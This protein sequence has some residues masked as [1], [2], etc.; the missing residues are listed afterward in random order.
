MIETARTRVCARVRVEAA[1][2]AGRDACASSEGSA[3]SESGAAA[4]SSAPGEGSAPRLA[5]AEYE[6]GITINWQ[7]NKQ[8]TKSPNRKKVNSQVRK[9]PPN[10]LM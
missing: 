8:T 2:I 7:T 10:S 4:E 9:Q 1:L 3:L 6:R 5:L